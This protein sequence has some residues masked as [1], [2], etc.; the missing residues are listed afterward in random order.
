MSKLTKEDLIADLKKV[1]KKYLKEYPKSKSQIT[2]TYYRKNGKYSGAEYER[3]FE[4]FSNFKEETFG[5]IDE[6][7]IEKR[8]YELEEENKQLKK[9][10]KSL[11]ERSISE[12]IILQMYRDNLNNEPKYNHCTKEIKLESDKEF[13]LNLSDIHC[14][15]V[16]LPQYV[17][18]ANSFNKDICIQRLDIIFKK[19]IKY[20]KRI[21]V[22]TLHLLLN[23]DLISG[24]IHRELARNSDL[25]EVESMFYIQ[26]YFM[27]KLCELTEHFN[28]INVHIII[29]NHARILEGRPYWKEKT[30]M[31]YEY[32]LGKQLQI[33]FETINNK[34]I[35][36][37]VPE[38]AFEVIKVK[39]TR[40]LVTHGD[41]MTGAG[42]GGFS[43]IPFYSICMSAAKLYGVLHQI[44]LTDDYQF[45]SII[46]G[47][48]HTSTEIPIFNGGICYVNGCVIGVNEFSINKMKSVAMKVQ[49]LLC[50]D[51]N[52]VDSKINIK[53]D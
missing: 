35:T 31:S 47:H 20:A 8:L 14:G 17:N 2:R 16:V 30:V 45:D 11:I 53:F 43:G 1:S 15:E 46:M 26:R 49:Q 41:V 13:V 7:K 50:V 22:N 37:N 21:G 5:N 23:G 18:Y 19:L 40:F 24:G 32:I 48:L 3:F 28:K 42:A 10:K 33:Y 27:K 34:K 12:E 36:I 29:G 38:S 51:N 4:S 9:D 52:G 44:G 25:N 6:F 39:N